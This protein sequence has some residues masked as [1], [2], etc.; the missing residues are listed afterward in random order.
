MNI[1]RMSHAITNFFL[2][3]MENEIAVLMA[4]IDRSKQ[5]IIHFGQHVCGACVQRP[6]LRLNLRQMPPNLTGF[7]LVVTRTIV[8]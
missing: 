5:T 3:H 8:D 4:Q 6:D 1:F 7:R 2:D